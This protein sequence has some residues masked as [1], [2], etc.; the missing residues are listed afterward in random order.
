MTGDHGS[1]GT[2]A[3]GYRCDPIDRHPWSP[4]GSDWERAPHCRTCGELRDHWTHIRDT[5]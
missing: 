2:A 3:N 5:A 1:P 4:T